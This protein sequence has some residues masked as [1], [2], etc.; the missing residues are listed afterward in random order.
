MNAKHQ[1]RGDPFLVEPV[2]VDANRLF[3]IATVTMV[4]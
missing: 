3:T 2:G 4:Q 1:I